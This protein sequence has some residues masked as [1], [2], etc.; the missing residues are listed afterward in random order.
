MAKIRRFYCPLCGEWEFM[1]NGL[2]G[3]CNSCHALAEVS[4]EVTEIKSHGSWYTV[5]TD[6]VVEYK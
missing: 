3:R 5:P 6:T 1:F 2:Y 4:D